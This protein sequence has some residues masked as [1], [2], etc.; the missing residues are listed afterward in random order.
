MSFLSLDFSYSAP[1]QQ[2]HVGTLLGFFL[3]PIHICTGDW[4]FS[5]PTIEIS[6]SKM[7]CQWFGYFGTSWL[8]RFSH[9][10]YL[11]FL[12]LSFP[13][14]LI[15]F[16]WFISLSHSSLFLALSISFFLY[17]SLSFHLSHNIQFAAGWCF[18]RGKKSPL[19]FYDLIVCL[20]T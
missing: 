1:Q 3:S 2:Q 10:R 18:H 13:L 19:S 17:I 16:Y 15:S 5:P 9:S 7:V 8:D 11:M 12:P 20:I 6:P 4:F 14:C